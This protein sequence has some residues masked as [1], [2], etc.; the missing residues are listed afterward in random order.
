MRR[1]A[2]YGGCGT[3]RFRR[4]IG[5]E[6]RGGEPS[7]FVI[8]DR[9]PFQAEGTSSGGSLRGVDAIETTRRE[10]ARTGLKNRV[11]LGRGSVA[12]VAEKR[13]PEREPTRSH[14]GRSR[15]TRREATGRSSSLLQ[16][17]DRRRRKTR[18]ARRPVS[19]DRCTLESPAQRTTVETSCRNRR[20]VSGSFRF[21]DPVEGARIW[22][23][24]AEA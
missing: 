5:G 13:P 7:R 9:I 14:E 1:Q 8:G 4:R 16:S 20:P 24:D 22:I 6:S 12:V 2:A 11:A 19:A 17:D 3:G 15:P 23:H 21:Q 18:D 10:I